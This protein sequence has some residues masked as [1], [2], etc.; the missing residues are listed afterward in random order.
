MIRTR[1]LQS[2]S[3][4]LRLMFTLSCRP[5][6]SSLFFQWLERVYGKHNIVGLNPTWANF[7]CGIEK[8]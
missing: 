8:P 2:P 5:L 7:L 1:S 6:S 4:D 3:D